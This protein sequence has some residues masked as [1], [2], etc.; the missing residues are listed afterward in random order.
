MADAIITTQQEV[1]EGRTIYAKTVTWTSTSS[2]V[3]AN[4]YT[5]TLT[6]PTLLVFV[7]AFAR[8]YDASSKSIYK[9]STYS[10]PFTKDTT[11]LNS[12]TVTIESGTVTFKA[13]SGYCVYNIYGFYLCY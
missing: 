13:K 7:V 1:P 10:M 12:I 4:S 6:Q 8:T 5:V 9:E 3:S 11:L 2:I